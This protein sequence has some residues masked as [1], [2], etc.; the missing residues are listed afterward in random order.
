[1]ETAL[2]GWRTRLYAELAAPLSDVLGDR[3]AKEFATLRIQTVGD[4]LRHIPR[5]YLSGTDL[6]DLGT[7]EAIDGGQPSDGMRRF[8]VVTT[9]SDT[10]LLDLFTFHVAREEVQLLPVSDGY[11]FHAGAPGAPPEAL[12]A[13]RD[14]GYGF[15]ENA[16]GAPGSN[17]EAVSVGAATAVGEANSSPTRA[18][19][20]PSR[21]GRARL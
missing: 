16:P 14:P 1:M 2:S 19:A 8:R 4:L 5:R 12:L 3:T 10:D 13:E 7:I 18:P 15:F 11:G 6:T 9:S 21:P 20:P 17:S